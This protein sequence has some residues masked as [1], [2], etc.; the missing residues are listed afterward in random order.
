MNDSP[1][2]SVSR[3]VGVGIALAAL[4]AYFITLSPTFYPGAS[5]SYAAQ[6]IGLTPF[7]PM[8]N[9]LW[10]ALVKVLA[11]L[12][13]GPLAVRL[14]GFSALCAAG[15]VYALFQLVLSIRPV[16]R[17][18]RTE[19]KQAA[20][21]VQILAA[22]MAAVYLAASIPFWVVATRA[23][24]LAFDLLLGLIPFLLVQRSVGRG[25]F[26]LIFL[27][28]FIYGLGVTEYSTMVALGP[29]LAFHMLVVLLNRDR[30]T[31][32]SVFG[33]LG[34]FLAGLFPYAVAAW[35]Y[36]QSP[37]Y[38]WR[39]FE[40]F[41]QVLKYIW[42]EQWVTLTRS[43][44]KVG[45]LTQGFL[46]LVPA[47]IAFGYRWAP[48]PVGLAARL[49]QGVVHL[50]VGGVLIG[51]LW[52][53]P[54][55]PWRSTHGEPM[56]LLPYVVA[57]MGMG[58]V[59]AFWVEL[60]GGARAGSRG[61]S[62]PAMAVALALLLVP[63][64]AAVKHLPITNGRTGALVNQYVSAV[65]DSQGA[66]GWLI[67]NGEHDAKL[68][69]LARERGQEVVLINPRMSQADAYQNYL[70][71]LYDDPRLQGLAR[72][73]LAPLLQEWLAQTGVVDQ[74]AGLSTPELF[75][76]LG[77]DPA[78]EG[79]LYVALKPEEI[80]DP[81]AQV[82]GFH[83]VLGP[84]G[85]QLRAA[86][87]ANAISPAARYHLGL[88]YELSRVANNLGVYVEDQGRVDLAEA[89]YREAFTFNTNN[90]SALINLNALGRRVELAD[91]EELNRSLEDMVKA[92]EGDY[93]LWSLSR[94]HGYVRAP[95]IYSGRGWAW[96]MS[97][98]P[99][100]A[101]RE[102]K[103]AMKTGG[104]TPGAQL[105]LAQMYFAQEDEAASEETFRKLLAVNPDHTAALLG[106]A[107]L[108]ARR[109]DFEEARLGLQRLVQLGVKPEAIILDQAAIEAASG[110]VNSA[111]KLLSDAVKRQPEDARAWMALA[112][113][114]TQLGDAK[115][116]DE[117][118]LKLKG[119]SKLAPPIRFALAQLALSRRDQSEARRQLEDV[120]RAQPTHVGALG[121]MIQIAQ[122]EGDRRQ[123]EQ[124]V[125]RLLSADPRSAMGNYLLGT[126]QYLREQYALAEASFR[127]SLEAQRT[128][129]VINALAFLQLL[130]GN[131]DEA[132]TLVR[133]SLKMNDEL[134]TAWDT[135]ANV[136][137]QRGKLA[138]AEE[139]AQKAVAMRPKEGSVQ[140][141]LVRLYDAQ[142]R[143]EEASK[144]ADEL[145]A[146]PVELNPRDRQDL[147]DILKRLRA[148]E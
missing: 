23:H 77:F 76:A 26:R 59:L 112:L 31:V 107:R 116:A 58:F 19:E 142:G 60:L 69:L 1:S 145:M 45:W 93:T 79:L 17:L 35:A 24:P 52:N 67:T 133:E 28:A 34:A 109:G 136:L 47:I 44:P 138:E 92:Q 123:L 135:L 71:S 85:V 57:A 88:L 66:R 141:T 140:T 122:M 61:L 56:I 10:G 68:A 43:M 3:F 106:L 83:R 81:V 64:A 99:G 101:V 89:L 124:Y 36:Q 105:A 33:L 90:I 63:V 18:E 113:V 94:L 143:T 42:L 78:P 120:L 118:L 70:A 75:E 72:V 126:F 111:A 32:G 41:G 121:L 29:V 97:G 100:M 27:A 134:P 108:A 21:P 114:A 132:E 84:L 22:S 30:F 62:K 65:L 148:G 117:A 147:R 115:R 73:G 95:E 25:H 98:K 127:V 7:P 54:L 110:D 13:L 125:N 20:D 37:A 128:A 129:D 4:A 14:N 48:R 131:L 12:P 74:V 40:G 11:V 96:A 15:A 104:S 8:G 119:M 38:G 51:V 82:D 46:T 55:A 103:R 6:H 9:I 2:G 137:I 91:K 80:L 50:L 39:A 130:K 146:D 102:I 49:G 53:M 86:V 139:A 5:A 16:R 144:L 87:E